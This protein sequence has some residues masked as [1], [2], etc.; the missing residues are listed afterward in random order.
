M[1]RRRDL[2]AGAPALLSLRL[3]RSTVTKE[4]LLPNNCSTIFCSLEHA[5]F[6]SRNLA[7]LALRSSL[8]KAILAAFSSFVAPAISP[9]PAAGFVLASSNVPQLSS[10]S[11]AGGVRTGVASGTGGRRTGDAGDVME[12]REEREGVWVGLGE[13]GE[14][15]G[16]EVGA[17]AGGGLA[18]TMGLGFVA[19][20]RGRAA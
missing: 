2:K 11:T 8:A 10:S 14:G 1:R 7:I 12:E 4:S 16:A 9:P 17:V 15:M 13:A 19:E 3:P 5:Y 6:F 20:T 18:R